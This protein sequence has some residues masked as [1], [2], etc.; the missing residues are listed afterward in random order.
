VTQALFG[1]AEE[2]HPEFEEFPDPLS[3]VGHELGNWTQKSCFEGMEV[4]ELYNEYKQM[5]EYGEDGREKVIS[6]IENT[7]NQ[8]SDI[9]S[10]GLQAMEGYIDILKDEDPKEIS[11]DEF[12][13]GISELGNFE[14]DYDD[15]MVKGNEALF[16]PL[17][18]MVKNSQSYFDG[19]E[20]NLNIHIGGES[21]QDSYILTYT[22]NG[23]GIDEETRDGMYAWNEKEASTGLPTAAEIVEWAGGDI[24]YYNGDGHYGHQIILDK[25]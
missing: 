19:D 20:D 8:Y 22:D 9:V 15:Q 12:M 7:D 17:C 23:S 10:T 14:H 2:L 24:E 21:D 18:T 6:E 11:V 1:D 25:A 16:I 4:V 5:L 13:S 3:V